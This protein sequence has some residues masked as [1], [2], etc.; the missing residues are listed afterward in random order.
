MLRDVYVYPM[1][2]RDVVLRHV[3]KDSKYNPPGH[4]YI[5]YPRNDE[6]DKLFSIPE[7]KMIDN[8]NET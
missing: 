6:A 1:Y 8:L 7:T 3:Y 4:I 5:F 2:T